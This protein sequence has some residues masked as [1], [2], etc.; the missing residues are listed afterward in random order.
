MDTDVDIEGAI[1]VAEPKMDRF[2]RYLL[3]DPEV[4][5][6]TV[7]WTRAT[8]LARTLTD[9]YNLNQWR[10]RMVV[11]GMG[12]RVDLY[13]LAAATDLDDKGTLQ[14]IADDAMDAA[15][16]GAGANIGTAL[17]SFTHR[18]NRGDTTHVPEQWQG[19]LSV[20]QQSL[21][22]QGLLVDVEYM[23]RVCVVPEVGV[24]GRFD[25]L[26]TLADQVRVYVVADLKTAKLD[27][28]QYQWLED[29]I[30]LSCY[31]HASH[32]WDVTTQQYIPMPPMVNQDVAYVI[33]L[34]NDA[35]P[36]QCVVY[37]LDIKKGWEFAQLAF[38]VREARRQAKKLSRPMPRPVNVTTDLRSPKAPSTNE[39]LSAGTIDSADPW[40]GQINAADSVPALAALW[41][42]GMAAGTWT[43]EHTAAGPRRQAELR[44]TS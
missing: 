11:A 10:N 26:V 19:H 12:K 27:S 21:R 34:P 35:R 23:E 24:A 17:H 22:D 20:Y 4:G 41:Q 8:T 25:N 13:T 30:Q 7:P 3:P 18:H 2:N 15:Q 29:S 32:I 40:L 36:P 5:G 16:A 44:G 42:R 1:G 43:P 6:A 37:E 9:E 33:H 28:L 38:T 31:A 39:E 14:R